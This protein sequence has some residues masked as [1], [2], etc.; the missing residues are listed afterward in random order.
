MM[1]QKSLLIMIIIIIMTIILMINEVLL[2]N[3]SHEASHVSVQK[4]AVD[5]SAQC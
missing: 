2:I 1:L 4:C 3:D 5:L